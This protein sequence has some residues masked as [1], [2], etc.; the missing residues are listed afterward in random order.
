M[1]HARVQQFRLA[2]E[3]PAFW[4]GALAI[5][6]V[7]GTLSFSYRYLDDLTRDHAGTLGMRMLEEFTSAY[8]GVVLIV[9]VVWLARRHPLTRAT[10]YRAL[11]VHAAGFVAFT[12]AFTTLRWASRS[13]LAPLVGL[14]PYDYG[15]FP[16]RFFMEAQNDVICYALVLGA[17][18]LLDAHRSRRARER[19]EEELRRHLVEAQ[20]RNLRLQLQPHFLFNALNTISQ[21]M[22]HDPSAADEMIGHLAELL[23]QSLRTTQTQEVPLAEELEL[24]E[25]YAAIMR[26]R[27]G[28]DLAIV[29]DVAADTLG[30]LVPSVLLQPLVENAVRHGNATRVGRGRIDVRAWREGGQLALEVEDDG[31]ASEARDGADGAAAGAA[32]TTPGVG[33][34]AT[35]ERLTLLF[36]SD[37]EFRVG[38]VP[39]RGFVAEMRLPFRLAPAATLDR[40]PLAPHAHADR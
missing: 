7:L 14:G 5:W 32:R 23:R 35:A 16:T 9:G 38:A 36:G 20:L 10:W 40:R 8:V 1:T 21:T 39:G 22:Y 34:T 37:H 17:L 28:D 30:A 4:L 26:A 11:P 19:R 29:I 33:L 24:L 18:A 25:C 15:R 6:T 13:A 12:I 27:F 31:A 2:G 3:G